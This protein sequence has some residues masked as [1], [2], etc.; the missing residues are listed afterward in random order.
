[1]AYIGKNPKAAWLNLE[2]QSVDPSNPEEGDIFYSDGTPRTE[3]PWVYVN[4]SWAQFSTGAAITSVNNLTLIPQ[5]SDPG[6]PTEGMLFYAD[7]T[8]RAEGMWVYTNGGW[9]QVTGLRYQEFKH[10]DRFKVRASG[11][12]NVN[13]SSGLENGDSFGGVTLAT[14]NLVLVKSNTTAS[15]NGVYIV[16]AT[17]AAVR[18]P[19]FDSASELTY[20]QIYVTA[21]TNAGNTYFQTA[22][23]TSLS[24]SQTWSTT[25]PTYSFTVPNEVY[26]LLVMGCGAGGAGRRGGSSGVAYRPGGSGGAGAPV[27]PP[28]LVPVTPGQVLSVDI[29]VAEFDS[30]GTPST[31]TGL[32]SIIDTLYFPGADRGVAGSDVDNTPGSSVNTYSVTTRDAVPTNAFASGAGGVVGGGGSNAATNTAVFGGTMTGATGG[33]A[34][35]SLGGGG[36]AGGSSSFGVGGNGGNGNTSPATAGS[37]GGDAPATSY[38]AGGGGGGGGGVVGFGQGGLGT[39]GYVR[40]SW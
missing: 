14:G 6:S 36:G 32:T 20:A 31:V 39:G 28:R 13:I 5:S 40:I 38:G 37:S 7:G 19:D 24:D 2:P 22:V 29:G 17:G 35:A 30:D 9:V 12:S 11:N 8:S 33:S 18:H 21:G 15:E 10:K 1:M 27:Q 34:T 4:G 26:Q 3:G 23:L 16:Q 25:P